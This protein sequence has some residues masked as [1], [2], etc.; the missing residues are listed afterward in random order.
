MFY[1]AIDFETGGLHTDDHESDPLIPKGGV[2]SKHYAIMEI[3]YTILDKDHQQ[4]IP[5][6]RYC[7]HHSA[8]ALEQRVGP[9]SKSMF[10]ETLMKECPTSNVTLLMAEQAI[11]DDIT[12]LGIK[13]REIFMLG[14]SIALD[15]AFAEHQMKTL[16]RHLHYR[17]A[18]I[19]SIRSM[20]QNHFEKKKACFPHKKT[21]HSAIEDI[22]ESLVEL[23]CIKSILG[24]SLF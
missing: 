1:L 14:N 13:P 22:K 3:A 2:G 6:R 18:D 7:I 8:S 21:T 24:I 11:I 10:A 12:F 23:E 16:S 5:F 20:F 9:W 17:L 15:W 19:S 4:I